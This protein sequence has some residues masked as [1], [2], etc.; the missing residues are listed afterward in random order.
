METSECPSIGE[1]IHKMWICL[2]SVE[3]YTARKTNE[4]K[5]LASAWMHLKNIQLHETGP[6][7]YQIMLFL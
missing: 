4:L 1:R 6:C 7:L 5:L 2:Q 3:Y